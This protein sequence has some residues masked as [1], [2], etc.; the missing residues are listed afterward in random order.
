MS[1][2]SDLR[3][4]QSVIELIIIPMTLA[5]AVNDWEIHISYMFSDEI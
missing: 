3:T 5:G 1:L 4:E 2:D